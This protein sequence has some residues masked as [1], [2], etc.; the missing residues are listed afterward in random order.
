MFCELYWIT[1]IVMFEIQVV[2]VYI[3]VDLTN[4]CPIKTQTILQMCLITN[5]NSKQDNELAVYITKHFFTIN[6]KQDID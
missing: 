4:S 5:T 1:E 2:S 6:W 3:Y